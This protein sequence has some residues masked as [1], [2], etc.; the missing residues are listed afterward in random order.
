MLGWA[1]TLPSSE[2]PVLERQGRVVCHRA[3]ADPLEEQPGRDP[4]NRTKEPGQPLWK[5]ARGVED[6]QP[7]LLSA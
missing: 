7:H 1:D 6:E 2:A 3:L 5:C 4:N